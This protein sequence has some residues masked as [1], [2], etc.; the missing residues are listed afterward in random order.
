MPSGKNMDNVLAQQ[1]VK[2]LRAIA[3]GDR[4]AFEQLYRLTSP[5]LFALALRTLRQPA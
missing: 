5:H 1:Q 4:Q 3:Q 2:L